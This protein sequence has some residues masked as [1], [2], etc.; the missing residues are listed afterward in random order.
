MV[1][2][3]LHAGGRGHAKKEREAREKSVTGSGWL[4]AGVGLLAKLE[5]GPRG[6]TLTTATNVLG[7]PQIGRAHV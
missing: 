1:D 2:T 3:T 5:T 7:V 6:R 4:L